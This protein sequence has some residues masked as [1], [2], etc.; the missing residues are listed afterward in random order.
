MNDIFLE[1]LTSGLTK[2]CVMDI[3]PGVRTWPPEATLEKIA[4]ASAKCPGTKIPFGFG[5]QGMALHTDQGLKRIDKKFGHALDATTVHKILENY[6]GD[7]SEENLNLAKSFLK[8][9]KD[10]EKF[11][12][13]Q[14]VFH[15]FGC[16]MLFLYDH[17][18]AAS[19]QVRLI[20]FVHAFPGNGIIDEG[21][22]FGLKNVRI[23]FEEY[24]EGS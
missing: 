8:K 23:L 7:R 5:V 10:L 24:I 17:G 4:R 2:P 6:L 12:E 22:L 13:S 14:T 1:N 11:F 15:N 3:K 21:F 19:A 9:M 18:N 20:D 16:S